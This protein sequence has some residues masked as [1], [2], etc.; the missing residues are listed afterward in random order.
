MNHTAQNEEAYWKYARK[1]SV[2]DGMAALEAASTAKEAMEVYTVA[3]SQEGHLCC[4]EA[5]FSKALELAVTDADFDVILDSLN[6]LG[7]T[8]YRYEAAKVF[9]RIDELGMAIEQGGI[10]K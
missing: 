1:G 8:S 3:D 7:L 10:K 6:E 5:A 4:C 2:A 9:E